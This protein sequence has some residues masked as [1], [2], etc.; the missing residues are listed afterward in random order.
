M[1]YYLNQISPNLEK[2]KFGVQ[3]KIQIT[4]YEQSSSKDHDCFC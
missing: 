3:S 4:L 1:Q 2:L